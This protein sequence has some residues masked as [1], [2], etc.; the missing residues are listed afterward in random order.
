MAQERRK[1]RCKQK[2]IIE[3][4]EKPA[5]AVAYGAAGRQAALSLPT[6]ADEAAEYVALIERQL[7]ARTE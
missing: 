4:M 7:G 3:L 2:A 1:F 6:P 5:T